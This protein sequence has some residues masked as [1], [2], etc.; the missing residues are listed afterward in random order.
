L[1]WNPSLDVIDFIKE[2]Y[3]LDKW[4]TIYY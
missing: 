1:G 3:T 2:N 4:P